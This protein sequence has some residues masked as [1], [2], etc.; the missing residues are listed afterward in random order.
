MAA[1]PSHN[2]PLCVVIVYGG[3]RGVTSSAHQ[4]YNP[5][6][7][8][9]RKDGFTG[10]GRAAFPTKRWLRRNGTCTSQMQ[11]IRVLLFRLTRSFAK[12]AQ[13]DRTQFLFPVPCSLFPVHGC[14]AVPRTAVGRDVCTNEVGIGGAGYFHRQECI[15]PPI[16]RYSWS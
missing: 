3:L 12:E 7:H 11:L 14:H 6:N 10:T 2:P 5:L 4:G 15:A 8:A 13:D 1:M 9:L 16:R